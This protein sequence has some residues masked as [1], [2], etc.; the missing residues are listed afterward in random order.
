MY[1]VYVIQYNDKLHFKYKYNNILVINV[2]KKKAL[3]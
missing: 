3:I 2:K 1:N